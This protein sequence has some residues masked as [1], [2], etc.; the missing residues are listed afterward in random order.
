MSKNTLVLAI[1]LASFAIVSTR[2]AFFAL[3]VTKD[4]AGLRSSDD[5]RSTYE[6]DLKRIKNLKDAK[7]LP[8]LVQLADEIESKWIPRN[9]DYYSELMIELVGAFSGYDF[10]NDRRHLYAIKYAKLALN[11][12]DQL[13]LEAEIRLARFLEG[14]PEYATGQMKAGGWAQDR[15]ER[16]KYWLHAWQRLESAINRNFDFNNRP[17][18][19]V[20]PPPGYGPAGIAPESI[21]DP[22]ARADYERAIAANKE[23]IAD[24]NKQWQLRQLD[25]YFTPPAKRF[26]V[27]AY[28]KPPYNL[29]ELR[30]NLN[31]YSVNQNVKNEILTLVSRGM[32]EG[33]KDP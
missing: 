22:K 2:G 21:K 27:E 12:G 17:V 19:N 4:T 16:V 9:K 26:L 28:S 15:S 30:V 23:K 29:E 25:N 3:P 18:L 13:P 6:E 10:R 1:M 5:L 33:S 20:L 31:A 7:D 24:Y 32:S 14:G 11:K 8:H